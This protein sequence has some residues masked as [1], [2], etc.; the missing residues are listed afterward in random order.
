MPAD[1]E[2][3]KDKERID[4]GQEDKRDM[5]NTQTDTVDQN[6]EENT[7]Q[8]ASEDTCKE[9]EGNPVSPLTS[10]QEKQNAE[11][12]AT[13]SD[14]TFIV[15]KQRFTVHRVILCTKSAFFRNLFVGELPCETSLELDEDP[16]V[17]SHFLDICYGNSTNSDM[18]DETFAKLIIM[19]VG[20]ETDWPQDIL[21]DRL[22]P[23]NALFFLYMFARPGF[24]TRPVHTVGY[25]IG[26]NLPSLLQNDSF[27]ATLHS[28]TADQLLSV[29]SIPVPEDD[30]CLLIT[31][32]L[33]FD[34][35]N[36]AVHALR[37]L[38]DLR[39]VMLRQTLLLHF[40][41]RLGIGMVPRR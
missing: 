19:C 36:R 31:Q 2:A 24:D 3:Q 25:Y 26:K 21:P 14:F 4:E 20:F 16:V 33:A 6:A 17:F 32:W 41:T 12:K 34:L 1:M 30:L 13:F 39:F 23:A 18:N 9:K 40:E 37:V 15:R 5:A 11:R 7:D 8:N 35:P 10:L 22:A 38:A 27:I 29:Y 28:L